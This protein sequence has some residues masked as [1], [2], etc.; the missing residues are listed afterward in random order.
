MRKILNLNQNWQFALQKP[1]M[2]KEGLVFTQVTLPHDWMISCPFDRNMK[3]GEAQGFFDRWGTGWYRRTL[4]LEKKPET[5][6]RLRFDGVYENSRVTVNGTYMGGRKYGY[7]TFTLDVTEALA[8]GE[9]EILVEVD[10]TTAPVDRWYTGAGIYRSVWLECLPERHLERDEV[11]VETRMENGLKNGEEEKTVC[12]TARQSAMLTVYPGCEGQVRALLREARGNAGAEDAGE[13]T[14][15]TPGTAAPL[16]VIA[17]AEGEGP[18]TLRVPDYQAWSDRNPKLYELTL[19]LL[20]QDTAGGEGEKGESD[21][22]GITDEL[23]IPVGFRSVEVSADRGLFINGES[24]KLKGVCVHQDISC[25]GTA[26][27]KELWRERLLSLKEI[28]CNAIRLAHHLYLPEMLELCDELGFYVY[29]EAFDKWTGG[30]YGRFYETEWEK[31]LTCMVKRDRNHPCILFWGVGNEVENQ[32][33]PSMLERLE[34]HVQTVKALDPARPVSLAMNPHFAYPTEEVDM[35]Q[36]EDIQQFVDEM[37]T[38]EIFDVDDRI[39]Q[40]AKIAEKVD[41]LSCNYQEQWYERIHE[42]IPDKAILG[43]ETYLFF[44]GEGPRFQ[45]FSEECPWMD[46]VEKD[47]CMGGFI[48]TGIDYWGESMGWPAKGWSGALFAADME[49]RPAAWQY[50][51]YWTR[52]PVVHFAVLDGSLPDEGVK[53]HWDSPSY[54]T[55]WEFPWLQR[56]VIPFRIATNCEQV[57]I[58][59]NEGRFAKDG[60]TSLEKE[61]SLRPVKEYQGGLVKGYLPWMPGTVTVIG[62]NGG[63]EVCRQV[64]ETPG[65]AVRLA[66][67][68]EEREITLSRADT[69]R[70]E[71]QPQ[72]YRMLCK[73]RAFDAEGRP[74]FRESAKVTFVVEGPARLI[75]V[76]NGDIKSAEAPNGGSI[77]LYRGRADAGILITGPGRVKLTAYAAGIQSAG[78]VIAAL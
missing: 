27:T 53:E 70:E 10:N 42:L 56:A 32:S 31:D 39:R 45:N 22:S 68:Q 4:L 57:R 12:Q 52:E 38:G 51:S 43:T 44:R 74:V 54:V 29:E 18:L 65:I 63:K 72:P 77:H 34:K 69:D 75:G 41:F 2:E 71:N 61:Y 73:V 67:E 28:G 59:L 20:A 11:R 8:D 21:L 25:F 37:K 76:D 5:V 49:K 6:Y 47:Y 46:V 48:W 9:N 36:V 35:S 33:Y 78:C 13:K 1:G 55:H 19:Q 3:Q 14:E 66:F 17:Q 15:R 24:V 58:I 30:A 40:I 64:V 23:T 50:R 26:V 7:S 62:M 16:P 60:K